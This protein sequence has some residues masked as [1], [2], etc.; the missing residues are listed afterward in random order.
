MVESTFEP[1]STQVSTQSPEVEKKTSFRQIVKYAN[2]L[3]MQE[4]DRGT[5]SHA[6]E[7]RGSTILG[8]PSVIAPIQLVIR[9]LP[10]RS[11]ANR[12]STARG[13]LGWQTMTTVLI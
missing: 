5:E 10:E 11:R 13:R 3:I 1:E 4:E 6:K 12:T 7:M 8:H 9:I 2:K